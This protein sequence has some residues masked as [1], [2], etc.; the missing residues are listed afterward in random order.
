MTDGDDLFGKYRLQHLIGRGAY[1]TVF[2]AEYQ[3]GYGFRKPVALKVMRRR[4]TSA[5]EPASQ[6]FLNEA[7]LGAAILHP[8]LVEFYECGRVGDRLYIAME[9]VPG[10]NL[11]DVIRVA[12]TLGMQIEDDFVMAVAQQTARGLAALHTAQVEGSP[13]WAIHRDLKP[14]NVLLSPAGLA[15]ITDYGIARYATDAYETIRS[16]G[17]RGSPLYMSPE[18]TRGLDLTQASDVFSFAS[19]LLELI[20]LRPVFG[21]PTIEGVVRKVSEVDAAD[22][23]IAARS[24]F[25]ELAPVLENCLLADPENRYPDGPALVEAL[26]VVEPP[27]FP[28]ESV[29]AIGVEVQRAVEFQREALERKPVSQFWSRLADAEEDSVSVSLDLMSTDNAAVQPTRLPKPASDTL[30]DS[31]EEEE[32]AG[33]RLRTPWIPWIVAAAA[34]VVIAILLGPRLMQGGAPDAA[35]APIVEPTASSE[36][37]HLDDLQPPTS[38]ETAAS[39]AAIDL[40]VPPSPPPLPDG[41]VDPQDSPRDESSEPDEPA[42]TAAGLPRLSMAPVSRGI[43]GQA[44]VVEARVQPPAQHTVTLW[45]RAAPTGDWLTQATQSDDGGVATLT[46]PAGSWIPQDCRSVDYFV[47]L[48]SPAGLVRSGSAARPH[49]LVLY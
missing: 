39:D 24:R 47:E 31:P 13:I 16:S 3:G 38:G 43:R 27:A 4:L 5:D 36:Y 40:E 19:T 30:S 34:L 22:A 14:G 7:R 6:E 48:S 12:P 20:N 21:S 1:S 44:T 49:E 2:R 35:D 11:A 37:E 42:P 15:K 23:L 25:P 28:E 46:I 32:R 33:P 41:V 18:Q 8:N 17:P 10:P 26:K 29:S 45:Y 9:L